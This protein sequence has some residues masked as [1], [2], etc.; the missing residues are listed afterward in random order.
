MEYIVYYENK[1]TKTYRCYNNKTTELF[2]WNEPLSNFLCSYFYIPKSKTYTSDDDSL[3]QYSKDLLEESYELKK[4]SGFDWIT[5]YITGDEKVYFRN[6]KK[7]IERF[8]NMHCRKNYIDKY[9]QIN[10]TEYDWMMKC[11]NAGL[12][13]ET[14]GTFDCHTKDYKSFY[15]YLMAHKDFVTPFKIG[16]ERIIK[17]VPDAP[18]FGF[19]KVII[20]TTDANFKKVFNY[21]KDNVYTHY[22]LKFAIK[23]KE[24][25]NL[26]IEL[27]QDGKPNAYQYYKKEEREPFYKVCKDWNKKLIEIKSLIPKNSLLKM[28][29]SRCWGV[30][31]RRN[32]K[33]INE[34]FIDDYNMGF[35]DNVDYKIVDVIHKANGKIVFETININRPFFFN[36]RLLPFL[37]SFG[38]A[39][40]GETV[41]KCGINDVIRV[42]TDSITST[43]P[44]DLNIINFVDE[45]KTSGRINFQGIAKSFIKIA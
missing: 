11:N 35:S 2:D 4:H 42:I 34:E 15:Q 5:P 44:I 45:E 7:N 43:K 12:Q 9:E 6:H 10:K 1:A 39:I 24:Q 18:I 26:K 3:I 40:V 19:Y 32:K 23:Y 14:V 8:F 29:S 25:F 20:S 36:F 37:N 13:Y 22:S 28:L 30:L 17:K 33:T 16:A 21:S 31:C 27:V 38:R 41:I